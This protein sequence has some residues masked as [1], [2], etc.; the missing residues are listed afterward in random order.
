VTLTEATVKGEDGD[1]LACAVCQDEFKVGAAVVSLPECGHKFHEDCLTPWLKDHNTCPTCRV[2]IP[3]TEQHDEDEEE[4]APP[5]RRSSR[6]SSARPRPR[7]AAPPSDGGPHDFLGSIMAQLEGL[8][9]MAHSDALSVDSS[10]G[11]GDAH[12]G[13]RARR[14][15]SDDELERA[16]QAS[17]AEAS[18]SSSS[19][20]APAVELSAEAES[21][22]PDL[23]A[24]GLAA[25]EEACRSQG[26]EVPPLAGTNTLARLLAK[27]IV[28]DSNPSSS[29]ST[30][31][32]ASSSSSSVP[33]A[34]GVRRP[35]VLAHAP[36]PRMLRGSTPHRVKL[37][38]PDSSSIEVALPDT[39]KLIDLIVW[40]VQTK[41]SLFL[42]HPETGY[43]LIGL[44]HSPAI[45]SAS[46][47][48]TPSGKTV[49]S[50]WSQD[51]TIIPDGAPLQVAQLT[52]ADFDSTG[53]V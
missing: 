37:F 53:C 3:D 7:E 10:D 47:S 15:S 34:E 6:R 33:D 28:E 25:L 50:P 43:P 41:P 38:L 14:A 5:R 8:V 40:I 48:S 27:R 52:V 18:S 36:I 17:L 49:L 9:G 42:S 23:Q 22:V 46:T 1:V 21:L 19:S 29:S 35:S 45:A 26:V 13:H 31:A 20:A 39:A 2:V 51:I 11:E 16:I 30:T 12:R 32:S 24:L 4:A 44:V